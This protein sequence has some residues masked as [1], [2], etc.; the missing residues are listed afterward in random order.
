MFT[1][2]FKLFATMVGLVAVLVM[3]LAMTGTTQQQ[4]LSRPNILGAIRAAMGA[5]LTAA[6]GEHLAL[7]SAVFFSSFEGGT[8]AFVPTRF[9]KSPEVHE[10][11]VKALEELMA[12]KEVQ[13]LIGGFYIPEETPKGL[14]PGFYLVETINKDRTALL[15]DGEVIAE[16]PI[17]IRR[18][19]LEELKAIMNVGGFQQQFPAQGQIP[20]IVL[21]TMPVPNGPTTGGPLAPAPPVQ[22]PWK[23]LIPGVICFGIPLGSG[24]SYDPTGGLLC[25]DP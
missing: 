20:V 2:K 24:F 6:V 22:F 16:L 17:S 21:A 7:D 11:Y 9:L 15:H 4:Q 3:G 19:S 13:L 25:I 10:Y 1:K 23:H 14:K 8:W 12:G 5:Q 18:V